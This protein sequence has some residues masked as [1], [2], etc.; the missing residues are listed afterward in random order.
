MA[1]AKGNDLV[2]CTKRGFATRA[3]PGSPH[4]EVL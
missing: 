1:D 2:G 4:G 3:V